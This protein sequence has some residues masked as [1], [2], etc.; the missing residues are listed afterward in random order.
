[1]DFIIAPLGESHNRKSF[2]CGE[3]LLDQYLKQYAGQDSK[4]R[5][6]KVYV[7]TSTKSPQQVIGYYSLSAASIDTAK[8]A[9]KL[10]RRLPRHPVP[11]VLLGRLAVAKSHQR[12]GL[13]AI[14]IADAL[15]HIAHASQVIAVYAVVVDAL[16]EQMAKFYRQFGFMPLPSQ[17]LKLFLPMDTVAKLAS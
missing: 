7:A 4:R 10:R 17:P 3:P 11:V 8:L 13:G 14:L 6:N 2:N 5:V 9:E 16:N 1:M 12:Q 15:Q